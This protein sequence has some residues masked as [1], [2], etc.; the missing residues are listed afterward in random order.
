MNV[1]LRYIGPDIALVIRVEVIPMI[2]D[3]KPPRLPRVEAVAIVPPDIE[4]IGQ[5]TDD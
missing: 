2:H 4:F 5:D 3:V 1:L